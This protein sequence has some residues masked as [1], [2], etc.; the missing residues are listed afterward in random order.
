ML[1]LRNGMLLTLTG[2]VTGIAGSLMLTKV[3]SVL[4]YGITATDAPTFLVATLLFTAGAFITTLIP[5]RR[6][7]R[8]DPTVAIRH[9]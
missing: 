6:A 5:A 9:E 8:L 3:I 4:L 7:A 1:V 2:V